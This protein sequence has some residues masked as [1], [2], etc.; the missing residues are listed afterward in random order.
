MCTHA[1]LNG[2]TGAMRR[3]VSIFVIVKLLSPVSPSE[4]V[5]ELPLSDALRLSKR[6][7][8]QGFVFQL[9]YTIAAFVVLVIC[10]SSEAFI[11]LSAS[12]IISPSCILSRSF[13]RSCPLF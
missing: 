3:T 13:C 2:S 8:K 5:T 6:H 10:S 7:S 12:S 1:R 4:V 11:I 9:P